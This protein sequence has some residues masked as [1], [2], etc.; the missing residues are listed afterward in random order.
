[1]KESILNEQNQNEQQ[2]PNVFA[3]LYRRI[4]S[5]LGVSREQ[6]SDLT[7]RFISESGVN[8]E[9]ADGMAMRANMSREL[10][11]PQMTAKVFVKGLKLLRITK[12][13]IQITGFT[14]DGKEVKVEEDGML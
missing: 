12:V 14:E 7:G 9:H 13:S 2:E 4:I 6:V 11:S 5:T 10:A 8:E 3:K 1:M